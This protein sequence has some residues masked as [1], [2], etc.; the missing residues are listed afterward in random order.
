M[1]RRAPRFGVSEGTPS[2]YWAN[3]GD[4]AHLAA[5]VQH[6]G[7][8]VRLAAGSGVAAEVLATR[9]EVVAMIAALSVCLSS[10]GKS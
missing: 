6:A 3:V 9:S 4:R 8:M 2:L 7:I 1:A 5:K 10:E